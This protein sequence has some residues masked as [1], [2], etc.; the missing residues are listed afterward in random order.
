MLTNWN[1]RFWEYEFFSPTWLWLLCIIPLVLFIIYRFERSRKGEVKFSGSTND[2]RAL[3]SNWI[4]R[5]REINLL[6]YGIIA[7]LLIFAMAQPFHWANYDN[8]ER[9]FKDGI[10]IVITLDVSGSMLA[11]D[12]SP[13]RLEVAKKV[14]KEFV[15]GRKGDRIGLIAYAGAAHTACPPTLD[16]AVLKQQ[17]DAINGDY[18]EGGTAIGEGLGLAVTRLRSDSL[19]SKVVILLTDGMDNGDEKKKSPL[20]AASLAKAKNVRVYT[21][22]VGSYGSAK[23]LVATTFGSHY[24]TR[25]VEINEPELKKIAK[26]TGGQYFR[27]TDE[28]NLRKIYKEIEALEKRKIEDQ[29][30]KSEPPSNP[31]AFLN[32]ALILALITWSGNYLVFKHND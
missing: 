2:Q 21:I 25:P 4:G 1:I 14:A 16:Y 28:E 5:L 32:W 27:A 26:M 22:G 6:V 15:D 17:I 24:K 20:E 31:A 23:S 29:H 30:F 3:G 9:D 11:M 13:N 8:S 10:D 19:K 18:L 7:A 12:F